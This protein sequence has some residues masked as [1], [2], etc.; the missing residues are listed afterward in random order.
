[1]ANKDDSAGIQSDKEG[2]EEAYLLQ[3]CPWCQ[4]SLPTHTSLDHHAASHDRCP[5]GH[6]GC[7]YDCIG[8]A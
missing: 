3:G 5:P 8:G 1:M 2:E 7:C 4:P 6:P